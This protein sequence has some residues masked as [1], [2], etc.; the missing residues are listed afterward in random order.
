MEKE[1]EIIGC[2]EVGEDVT[3]DTFAKQFI[4]WIEQKGWSFGGGFRTIV[5]GYYVDANGEPTEAVD[6]MPVLNTKKVLES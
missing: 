3:V 6:G 5:D 1:I 2:V 4:E